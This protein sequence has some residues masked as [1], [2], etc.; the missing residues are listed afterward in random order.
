[1]VTKLSCTAIM[2][3]P[4]GTERRV[5]VIGREAWA[6][7]E[8]I[9]HGTEGCTP[10]TTPGPR[11][12]HYVWLLRSDGIVVETEHEDHAGP[13]SGTH[14]RYRLKSQV[15]LEGGNLDEWRPHG[16]RQPA[17]PRVAAE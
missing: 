17:T 13:F 4:D 1:M 8:L 3:N 2:T 16:V 12:S 6:L 5:P 7:L 11:W 9:E 10:I 15:R 14:A